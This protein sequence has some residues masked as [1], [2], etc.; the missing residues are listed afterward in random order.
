MHLFKKDAS[1]S[2]FHCVEVGQPHPCWV[3]MTTLLISSRKQY[4][5]YY[6]QRQ[7]DDSLSWQNDACLTW[8]SVADYIYRF[9]VPHIQSSCESI[10]FKPLWITVI[11]LADTTPWTMV[12]PFPA[13]IPTPN[14]KEGGRYLLLV[15]SQSFTNKPTRSGKK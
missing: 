4:K 6:C 7:R 14:T 10:S 11:C 1:E 8:D 12:P 2:K 13:P 3:Y 5:N 15:L 9:S